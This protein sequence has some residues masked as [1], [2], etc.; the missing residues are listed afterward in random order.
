LV[1]SIRHVTVNE[2]MELVEDVA[3]VKKGKV[4]CGVGSRKRACTMHTFVR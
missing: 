4:R 3:R 2:L 1:Y